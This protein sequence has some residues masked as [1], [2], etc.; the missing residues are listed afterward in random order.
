M[1]A[2]AEVVVPRATSACRRWCGRSRRHDS[3]MDSDLTDS[4]DLLQRVRVLRVRGCSPK[5]IARALGVSAARVAPIVRAVAVERR[6]EAGEAP[7]VG[8]W[9]SQGWRAGLTVEGQTGWPGIEDVAET[10]GSGL[11]GV[12]V[13]RERQHGRVSACGYLVDVYCL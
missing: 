9:V 1:F 11:V 4:D 10:G 8:C 2:A 7:V 5:E 6:A 13:A 3:R 12:L